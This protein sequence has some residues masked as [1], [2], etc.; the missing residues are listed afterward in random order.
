MTGALP[1]EPTP[2]LPSPPAQ[3]PEGNPGRFPWRY[4][5]VLFALAFLGAL[6][7]IPY[8]IELWRRNVDPEAVL[9][10]R[11]T[12]L[13]LEVAGE[14]GGM[15][16][17][18]PDVIVNAIISLVA[19]LMGLRLG[20][21]LGLARPPLAGSGP[22]PARHRLGSTLLLSTTLGVI[23][24]ILVPFSAALLTASAPVGALD[25]GRRI[26]EP[27]WWAAVLM[28]V[29]A[30]VREEIWLRLGVMTL[31]I[32]GLTKLV[33]RRLPGPVLVW[34]GIILASLLFGMMHLPKARQ[35]FGL[36][37]PIIVMVLV[38]NGVIA[39][40]FGWLYWRKGLVA[41]M[42]AHTAQDIVNHVL[43]PLLGG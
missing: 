21:P 38:G 30:G 2:S 34:S 32:W 6:L 41:A 5:V 3:E 35:L 19:I 26:V 9:A 20:P 22:G 42:T 16:S 8:E 37:G 36:S 7:K 24:A 27:A 4:A 43:L 18:P 39:L 23:G 14:K 40:I 10:W 25:E 31:I 29:S 33:G 12:E 17:G 15:I 28:S 1:H 13:T 11:P